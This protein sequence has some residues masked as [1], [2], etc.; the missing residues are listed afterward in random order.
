MGGTINITLRRNAK[1]EAIPKLYKVGGAHA[2]LFGSEI[3]DKR[4]SNIAKIQRVEMQ[5]LCS[6]RGRI[7]LDYT[8][9]YDIRREPDVFDIHTSKEWKTGDY[10]KK[11]ESKVRTR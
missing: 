1:R 9:N 3:W 5:F 7:R 6:V 4:K 2:I 10:R 11:Q 8:R